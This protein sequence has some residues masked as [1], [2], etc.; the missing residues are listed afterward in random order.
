M[1][2]ATMGAKWRMP[3]FG[4]LMGVLILAAA[5]IG[6]Q[7]ALGLG[8]FA[9]MAAYSGVILAFG[10]RSETIGVLGGR[11]VDERLAGFDLLATA[12]AG[13]VAV[14]VAIAGFLW[15]IAT[16]RSGNDFAVVA[17]SAGIAYL[18]AVLWLRWRA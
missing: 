12:A 14:V 16:G 15:A 8:M 5:A 17:A 7:P 6:G 4:L 3:A 13:T 18:A 9:I 11:P 10:E 1:E 2:T